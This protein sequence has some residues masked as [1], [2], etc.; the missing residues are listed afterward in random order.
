MLVPGLDI[1]SIALRA[2]AP[3]TFTYQAYV[4]RSIQPNGQYLA[5]YAAPV[6]MTG[7]AQPVP[8]NLYE[9]YGL[10]FDKNYWTFFVQLNA[11]DISRDVAGDQIT[12]NGYTFQI[13]QKTN[14]FPA[15]SWIQFLSIQVLPPG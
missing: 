3:Q 2:I 15:D 6:T 11:V 14:W 10:Q 5:T 1:L 8:R 9:T 7:S 4:N 13:M 12:Y